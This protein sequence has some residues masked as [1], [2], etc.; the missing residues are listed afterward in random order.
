[1]WWGPKDDLEREHRI[2]SHKK[3]LKFDMLSMLVTL[4]LSTAGLVSVAQE[5]SVDYL[6]FVSLQV[7]LALSAAAILMINFRE[8]AFLIWRDYFMASM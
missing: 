3:R 6:Y 2:W 8:A 7:M 1:M 5:P 4:G